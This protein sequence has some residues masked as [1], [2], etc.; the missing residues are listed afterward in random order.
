MLQQRNPDKV[1]A[2]AIKVGMQK[3]R[4]GCASCADGYFELA[5]QYG[6]TEEEIRQELEAATKTT[7]KGLSRRELIKL[8]ASGGLALSA[9]GLISKDAQ[10]ISTWWGTDSN[11]QTCCQM[12]QNFYI[13]RMGYGNEPNGDGYFFNTHAATAAGFS[14]T[15][16]YWGVVGPNDSRRGNLSPYAWGSKQADLAWNAWYNSPNAGFIEGYTVFGDIEANFG[17]WSNGNYSPNQDVL[18]GFCT[19]LY[20]ITPSNPAVWP[21][22]YISPNSWSSYFGTSFRTT[23]SFVLWLTGCDTC[24]SDICGPCDSSCNTITTVQ[25]RLSATIVNIGLGT[26]KPVL[27]QYWIDPECGSCGDFNV[28]TQN[29]NSFQVVTG[30]STYSHC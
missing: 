17:G 30:G 12:P 20:N 16:G 5:K 27:W 28:A 11:S 22:I 9:I 25:N 13:G 6:A 23:N 4:S 10:A 29:T 21:G 24:G 15:F 19:E 7:K 2:D 3:A 8:M 18:N 14:N 26:M 1:H